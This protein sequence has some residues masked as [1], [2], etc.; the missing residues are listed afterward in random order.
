MRDVTHSLEPKVL[1]ESLFEMA[2]VGDTVMTDA[3][4]T[5]QVGDISDL[6]QTYHSDAFAFTDAE[7]TALELYDQLQEL[8]LQQSLLEAQESG[9]LCRYTYRSRFQY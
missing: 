8:E 4:V 7:K 5:L 6:L 9:T 3:A 1:L 2:S